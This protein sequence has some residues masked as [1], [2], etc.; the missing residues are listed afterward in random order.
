MGRSV[1]TS[2]GQ[3]KPPNTAHFL[4]GLSWGASALRPGFCSDRNGHI[5]R[6][7][8]AKSVDGS[9]RNSRKARRPRG[10]RAPINNRRAGYQPGTNLPYKADWKNMRYWA[11]PPTPDLDRP[12]GL[13]YLCFMA[14]RGP[15]ALW[16][17]PEHV[18][19]RALN[20]PV[21]QSVNKGL[22]GRIF[23]DL[24]TPNLWA[25]ACLIR[26]RNQP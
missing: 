5:C 15:Q 22:R 4:F 18:G 3:A 14:G 12:N 2:S 17:K 23:N 26:L 6:W 16:G 9:P 10:R 21:H 19:S 7:I 11:K 25:A 8:T 13:S 24:Q 1:E 20:R